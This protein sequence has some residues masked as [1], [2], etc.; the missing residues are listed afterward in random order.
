[1]T[2]IT[3]EYL[4]SC[5]FECDVEMNFS[6]HYWKDDILE[7]IDSSEVD[8]EKNLGWALIIFGPKGGY[9]D[10]E[11]IAHTDDL[12]KIKKL[13]ELYNINPQNYFK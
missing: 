1:M 11:L 7:L 6:V 10:C 13:L 4:Q 3:N 12:D 8:P 2:K 9:G 5:G